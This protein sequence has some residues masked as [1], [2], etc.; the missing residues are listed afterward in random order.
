MM[1]GS[2]GVCIR[3]VCMCYFFKSPH[4]FDAG[5]DDDDDDMTLTCF[6]WK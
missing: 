5:D 1:C 2:D 6:F 4:D 3:M